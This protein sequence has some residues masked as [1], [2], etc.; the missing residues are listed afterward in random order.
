[1]QATRHVAALRTGMRK[2][3]EGQRVG[4]KDSALAGVAIR[5]GENLRIRE[6]ERALLRRCGR[7]DAPVQPQGGRRGEHEVVLVGQRRTSWLG[8]QRIEG[9]MLEGSVGNDNQSRDVAR[10][11]GQ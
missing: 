9:Q 6:G 1:W 11:V 7:V 10:Q 8:A 2:S 5:T 3:T 4:Q